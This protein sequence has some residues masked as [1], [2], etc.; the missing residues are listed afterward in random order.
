MRHLLD[1]YI[2]AAE[3]EVIS[4]FGEMS[5]LDIVGKVGLAEA[6]NSLPKKMRANKE[7]VAETIENN[8]R[9]KIIKEF[10]I[11]PAFFEE[12]SKLLGEIIRQ[13]REQALSYEEY[14]K[15]IA[16]LILQVNK[17]IKDNTPEELNTKAKRVL[18][19]N[20]G[21]KAELA[22][23]LDEKIKKVKRDSWRGNQ[24][25]ENEIKLGVYEVLS[26]K[27]PKEFGGVVD[28]SSEFA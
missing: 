8:V 19:N 17:G 15:R 4:P 7:A 16:E 20:L 6:I 21:N 13:R 11:D 18:Y 10:L 28:S 22:L 26:E 5:L 1:T 3:S 23:K 14:L 2:Q 12:M 27:E 24:A 25:K 9:R